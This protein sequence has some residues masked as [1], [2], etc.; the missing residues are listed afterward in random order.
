M[1]VPIRGSGYNHQPSRLYSR[2]ALHPDG[3]GEDPDDITGGLNLCF[4]LVLELE[5]VR[6]SAP[7]KAFS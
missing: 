1:P 3:Y 7:S 2:D 5:A 6:P 4:R